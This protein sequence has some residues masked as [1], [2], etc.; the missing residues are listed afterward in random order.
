M[1]MP[2]VRDDGWLE[3]VVG[4]RCQHHSHRLPSKGGLWMDSN[5]DMDQV[6]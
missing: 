6:E 1:K 2:I 4:Y 3:V 5:I